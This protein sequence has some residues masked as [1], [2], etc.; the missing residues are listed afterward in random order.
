[1]TF[2]E[3]PRLRWLFLFAVLSAHALGQNFAGVLTWHNDVARTG[4]NLLET[5]L[6][7]ANVNSSSFGKLLSYPV[8]GQI[9]AQPLYL[10]NV[11]VSG[12]GT[13]NLAYVATE[14][15]QVYA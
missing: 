6:T 9:Y 8:Q 12:Q 13:H 11:S 2:T 3:F 5:Q 7:T 14:H 4:Q 15:D 1:M 10:P